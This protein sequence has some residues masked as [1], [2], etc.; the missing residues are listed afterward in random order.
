MAQDRAIIDEAYPGDIVGLFDSG[1]FGIGDTLCAKG[2]SFKFSDFPVFP[3]EHFARVQAKD[4]MKRKQFLKGMTQLTQEGAIQVFREPEIGIESFIIG[5]VGVLQFEVLEYRLKNEYGVDI[6]MHRLPYGVARYLQGK[7]LAEAL[8][9]GL[10]SSA[11]IVY[12]IRER[13][14]A[15]FNNEWAVQWVAERHP[16]IEFLLAPPNPHKTD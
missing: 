1:I 14:V 6:S 7:G 13:P 8:K 11:K 2:K 5:A 9:R 15:L 3:P 16:D 12:D 4:T 10:D